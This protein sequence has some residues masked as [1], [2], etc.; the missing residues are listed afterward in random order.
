[1][2]K[3]GQFYLVAAMLIALI[4]GG[5]ASVSTRVSINPEPEIIS[6]IGDDLSRESYSI[7]EYGVYN[8]ESI[9][10]LLIDFAGDQVR[11]YF[12]KK[13]GDAN[14]IFLFG[15]RKNLRALQYDSGSQGEI[16]IGSSK[17]NNHKKFVKI[18]E[19][20]D[21]SDKEKVVVELL[22]NEYDFDI[23]DNEMFY[24]VVVKER[25]K[26]FFVKTSNK[27]D[28]GRKGGRG[29]RGGRSGSG[30]RRDGGDDDDD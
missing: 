14:I 20:G 18:K 22:G 29:D 25:E 30:G 28:K 1:M 9:D 13:T 27:K 3:R 15:D 16:S 8:D 24:F 12:L 10:P 7:I 19:L 2:N 6:E 26:E 17:W 21:F 5:M 4:V 23:R 11:D